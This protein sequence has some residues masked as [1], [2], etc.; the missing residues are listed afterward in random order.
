MS[1]LFWG[2]PEGL[3]E[4]SLTGGA[5]IV[6]FLLI[7]FFLG[8]RY[9]KKYRVFVWVL[10][11]VR[12]LLPFHIKLWDGYRTVTV[13]V[14]VLEESD[15]AEVIEVHEQVF[16]K[17]VEI[18][19]KERLFT[20]EQLIQ[21]V[22]LT[23]ACLVLMYFLLVNYMGYRKL[24]RNSDRCTD[25]TILNMVETVVVEYGLK[26]AVSVYRLKSAGVSPCSAG[27]FRQCIFLPGRVCSERE[28]QYI[29]RH[30][31]THCRNH[32]VAV[33][34]LMLMVNAIHWFNPLV[35]LMFTCLDQ[36]MELA[37][38]E[39]VLADAT[40][41]QRKEYCELILSY[42]SGDGGPTITTGYAQGTRFLKQR[43]AHIY[44]MTRKKSGRTVIAS[45]LVLLLL[46]SGAVK[47]QAEDEAVALPSYHMLE[48]EPRKEAD[49]KV[50][51]FTY[52]PKGYDFV[53]ETGG[54]FSGTVKYENEGEG[55][56][57]LYWILTKGKDYMDGEHHKPIPIKIN[58]MD[59]IFW[60][61]MDED[62]ANIIYCYM[63]EGYFTLSSNLDQEELMKVA[64]GVEFTFE[65]DR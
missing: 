43:F 6:L 28:L 60:E 14:H 45:V 3:L 47:L 59:G 21:L 25:E 19:S 9:Q 4:A 52:I 12:L 53:K 34:A 24:H 13:P 48:Y 55:Y 23:G 36:D 27:V 65:N 15:G 58:G 54:D 1:E 41:E 57:S 63:D 20:T 32:D 61:A 2:L 5:A 22:W 30:E 33:K 64:E 35:W 40:K 56:I 31:L 17:M 44:D 16:T 26:R 10:I 42:I 7:R 62:F 37:C 18:I 49:R 46:C 11:A 8:K 38:D 39:A 51:E 50:I 29:I